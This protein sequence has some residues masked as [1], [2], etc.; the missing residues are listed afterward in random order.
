MESLTQL[1]ESIKQLLAKYQQLLAAY[2]DLR[3][4]DMD[5]RQELIDTHAELKSL[6]EK[7]RQLLIARSLSETDESREAAKQQLTRLINQVDHALEVLKK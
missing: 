1:E 5:L 4:K 3:Q 6:R 2:E 7:N